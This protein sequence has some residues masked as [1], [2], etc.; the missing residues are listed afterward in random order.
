MRS[1]NHKKIVYFFSLKRHICSFTLDWFAGCFFHILIFVYRFCNSKRQITY[2]SSL[3]HPSPPHFISVYSTS[4]RSSITLHLMQQK[5]LQPSGPHLLIRSGMDPAT[6]PAYT[7]QTVS[8][9]TLQPVYCNS[10]LTTTTPTV[11]LFTRGY[12]HSSALAQA[13]TDMTWLK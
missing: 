10:S 7:V 2:Q 12:F 8:I 11:T 4:Y 5:T 6:V 3:Q 13:N 9:Y 1:W